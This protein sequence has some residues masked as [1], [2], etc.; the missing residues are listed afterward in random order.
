MTSDKDNLDG[1]DDLEAIEESIHHFIIKLFRFWRK[2]YR[3]HFV[4][5]QE[6]V[7]FPGVYRELDSDILI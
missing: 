3:E 4:K 2:S 1:I 5:P 7:M 6:M